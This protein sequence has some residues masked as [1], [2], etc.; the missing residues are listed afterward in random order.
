MWLR[1][2]GD[3]DIE[4]CVQLVRATHEADGYPRVWP[5]EPERFVRSRHEI[6]AWVVEDGGVVRGHVALH[7]VA[8]A[9]TLELAH[10]VTGRRED[11]LAAVARLPTRPCH[12]RRGFGALL[13][14][15]GVGVAHRLGRQP[16][17]DG[18]KAL[19]APSA[20]YEA[21]GWRRAGDFLL[22]D[23]EAAIDLW[24]Y[25]GPEPA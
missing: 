10:A 24:V 16:V 2:R 21:S 1:E 20:L 22:E 8:T 17:P 12:R 6:G 9:P 4:A 5:R 15:H 23:T 25:V 11:E 7:E 14:H 13:V 3:S 18:D 19:E